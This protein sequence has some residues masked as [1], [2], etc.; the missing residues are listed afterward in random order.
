MKVS[1][2]SI[3][4]P[5]MM[6]L[7]VIGL[8]FCS[9]T[10][11]AGEDNDGMIRR[12]EVGMAFFELGDLNDR[13]VNQGYEGF[14]G[15]MF[16]S[17]ASAFYEVS[18][19]VRLG[20]AGYR[21]SS[22][23]SFENGNGKLSLSFVGLLFESGI[24]VTDSL[25]L[26]IGSVAGM[27]SVDLRITE[28]IPGSFEGALTDTPNRHKVSKSFYGIQPLLS[29][30]IGISSRLALR[31]KLGYLW[32]RSGKWNLD[33]KK[34]AGPLNQIKAPIISIGA[35]FGGIAEKDNKATEEDKKK[36]KSN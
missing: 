16:L 27:G 15:S 36:D 17:G 26:M 13:L 5:L 11:R 34:F 20:G 9:F 2:P 4:Y 35:H 24:T 18:S 22:S 10:A 19:N 3:W 1:R 31:A 8:V 25:R 29:A 21:G 30:E 6:L 32:G 7:L 14:S 28:N 12:G 23:N 33:G